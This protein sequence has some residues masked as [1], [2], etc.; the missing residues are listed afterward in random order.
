MTI[1]AIQPSS[2]YV[3]RAELLSTFEGDAGFVDD[4]VVMFLGRCPA[5]I[6]EIRSAFHAGD[7]G[8]VTRAAHSLKGSIGYFEQ[9]EAYAAAQQIE[10]T[11]MEE[12]PRVPALLVALE[13]HLGE[14]TRYLTEEC[15]R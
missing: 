3:T 13:R 8:A 7:A 6:E 5:L 4:L 15:S 14:L 1:A 12:L 2:P 11:A 10:R 9:G